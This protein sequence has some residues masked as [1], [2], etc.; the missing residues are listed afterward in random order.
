M[1]FSEDGRRGEDMKETGEDGGEIRKEREAEVVRVW[2]ESK[3]KEEMVTEGR[4]KK[5]A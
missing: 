4:G 1:V 5:E 2:K 3:R